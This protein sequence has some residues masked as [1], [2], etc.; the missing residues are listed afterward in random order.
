MRELGVAL[1][2]KDFAHEQIVGALVTRVAE[3]Q[4]VRVSQDLA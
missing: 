3:E 2:G 1:F 4:E